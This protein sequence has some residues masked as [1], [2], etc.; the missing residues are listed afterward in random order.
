MNN[1]KDIQEKHGDDELEG[2]GSFEIAGPGEI[3]GNSGGVLGSLFGRRSNL[4]EQELLA[5]VAAADAAAENVE[6]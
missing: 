1:I 6:E 3:S 4:R 2:D 5:Q